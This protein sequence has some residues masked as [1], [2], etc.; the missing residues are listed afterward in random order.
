MNTVVLLFMHASADVEAAFEVP[1]LHVSLHVAVEDVGFDI[2]L[3]LPWQ[4]LPPKTASGK[5]RSFV[6]NKS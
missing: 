4:V 1:E 3:R 2:C 5:S 6:T